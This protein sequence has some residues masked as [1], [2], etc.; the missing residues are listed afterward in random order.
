MVAV[1]LVFFTGS[2]SSTIKPNAGN[3]FELHHHSAAPS[4]SPW[5]S[6]HNPPFRVAVVVVVVVG[7][8]VVVVMVVFCSSGQASKCNAWKL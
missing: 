4:P 6:S 1:A 7:V 3:N 8:V 5:V 2:S